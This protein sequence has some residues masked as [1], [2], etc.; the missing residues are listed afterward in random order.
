[1]YRIMLMKSSGVIDSIRFEG[2]R[3]RYLLLSLRY[4]SDLGVLRIPQVIMHA[5]P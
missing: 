3:Y 4:S 2:G 1:M 5:V